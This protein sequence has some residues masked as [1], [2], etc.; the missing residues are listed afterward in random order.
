MHER[1]L[2]RSLLKQVE[3][4]GREHPGARVLRVHVRIGEF[5]GVEPA[6][7]EPAFE[8]LTHAT[9]MEGARLVI[10]LQPLEARCPSCHHLFRIEAFRFECPQCHDRALEIVR[11]EELVLE[12]VDLEEEQEEPS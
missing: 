10:Q 8:E 4:I 11:G 7:L 1:T 12:R 3:A 2:V 5:S 9:D 6:L